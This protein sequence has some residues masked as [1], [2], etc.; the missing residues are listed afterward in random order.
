M[1][2]NPD[3]HWSAAFYKGL[4]QLQHVD[5][6]NFVNI[7][8]DDSTGFRL[9]T[10]TMCKQCAT[11]AVQG[12]ETLTTRTGYVNKYPSLL[13]TTSYNFTGTGTTPEL[14]AGVV[15]ASK[16]HDKSPA[17]H[18][19]NMEMLEDVEEMLAALKPPDTGHPKPIDCIRVDGA[20]DEGPAHEEVQFWW[21][22]RHIRRKKACTVVTSRSSG[23]S[24]LNRVELQNGC[25]S[26]GHADT[27]IPSTL[28]GSCMDIQTGV[29]DT[30]KF[31]QKMELAIQAY[32]SRVNR[33]SCGETVIHLFKGANSEEQQRIR[34]KL[35]IFLKGSKKA[36][37]ELQECPDLYS[38]MESVWKTGS[39]HMIAD[40]LLQGG[41]YPS[42]VQGGKTKL[43]IHMVL[44]RVFSHIPLPVLDHDRPWGNPSCS[45]CQGFCAGHYK[46]PAIL[47]DTT[48]KLALRA[49]SPPPSSV[50]KELFNNLKGRPIT[51]EFLQA[52]AK[53]VL[54]TPE[55][56]RIWL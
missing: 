47:T 43:R 25:L 49:T 10:L 3:S 53:E 23:S 9:D 1:R 33:S 56:V 42:V 16:L 41:V 7:N 35:T 37:C 38:W 13:P 18:A 22:L 32:I 2:F 50:L 24:Y 28:A 26:L 30:A 5:G 54:L 31:K 39:L 6:R 12:K 51:D 21:T 8:S 27:F 14:C 45:R 4:N 40:L 29:V 17:Q 46:S 48:N 20:V 55:G 11:P 44:R 52:A 19:A 34:A 36:K 15:K